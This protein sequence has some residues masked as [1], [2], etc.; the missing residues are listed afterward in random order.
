M[1]R[2]LKFLYDISNVKSYSLGEKKIEKNIL[3]MSSPEIFTNMISQTEVLR[4]V[5]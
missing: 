2:I 3:K 1:T 4:S 5:F